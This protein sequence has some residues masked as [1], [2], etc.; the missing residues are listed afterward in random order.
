MCYCVFPTYWLFWGEG[1]SWLLAIFLTKYVADFSPGH[2]VKENPLLFYFLSPINVYLQILK[3]RGHQWEINKNKFLFY[4]ILKNHNVRSKLC[5]RVLVPAGSVAVQDVSAFVPKT[6]MQSIACPSY[7]HQAYYSLPGLF[8]FQKLYFFFWS[9]A[10]PVNW[11]VSSAHTHVFCLPDL[12]IRPSSALAHL[13]RMCQALDELFVPSNT[14]SV[15]NLV[16][17]C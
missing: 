17:V 13:S 16:F 9:T 10:R 2:L 1:E 12:V 3:F 7:G 5:P 8:L 6:F 14:F 11:M 15:L 4:F